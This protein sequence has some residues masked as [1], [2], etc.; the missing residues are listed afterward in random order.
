MKLPIFL[1]IIFLRYVF[2]IVNIIIGIQQPCESIVDC[3]S[4][5]DSNTVCY[6][7]Y[8]VPCRN[9]SE[10]CTSSSHCCGSSRCFRHRCTALYKTGQ[11]C[12]LNRQCLDPNDFCINRICTRCIQLWASCSSD[13]L[14]TP[15]CVGNGICRSG[16]CQ[17]ARIHSQACSSS[18]DCADELVCLSGTCQNP[19]GHC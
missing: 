10:S 1:L 16:K 11:S 13:P 6:E 7:G 4:S 14:A 18:F 12:R 15:C 5:N 8:C 3:L 19:L 2:G 9:S 17:P